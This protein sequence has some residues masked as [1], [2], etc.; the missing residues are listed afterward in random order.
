MNRGVAA[1]ASASPECETIAVGVGALAVVDDPDAVLVTHAL[2]SCVAVCIWDPEVRVAGLLHFLLPGS[3]GDSHRAR[4]QPEA[5]ANSGIPLLFKTAY[6]HGLQKSRAVVY[7]VGGAEIAQVN[8][9]SSRIGRRN[10]I[11]ARRILWENGV[12]IEREETGGAAP[13][14]VYLSAETGRLRIRAGNEH[15][16]IE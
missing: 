1:C 10:V 16:V 2:G 11:A 8:M 3:L 6:R 4:V 9:A 15:V 7:L 5:F 13:R 14:S 12:L